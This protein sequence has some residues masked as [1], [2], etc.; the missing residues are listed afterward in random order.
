[1]AVLLRSWEAAGAAV[2]HAVDC[3][4][5]ERALAKARRYLDPSV[6]IPRPDTHQ[7]RGCARGWRWRGMNGSGAATRR[8]ARDWRRPHIYSPA[9]VRVLLDIARTYP[10]PRAPLRPLT[11]YTMLAVGY[12]A[13]LRISEST[14]LS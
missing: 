14:R 13:G 4:L 7:Q 8:W 2:F 5:L 1:M 3:E 10:S 6:P 11:L 9:Q 12:C